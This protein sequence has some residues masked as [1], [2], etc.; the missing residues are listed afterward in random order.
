VP[1]LSPFGQHYPFII[2]ARKPPNTT[3]GKKLT[4]GDYVYRGVITRDPVHRLTSLVAQIK[5]IEVLSQIS[6]SFGKI[7]RRGM[8]KNAAEGWPKYR[9]E[10]A[11]LKTFFDPHSDACSPSEAYRREPYM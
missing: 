3:L 11:R 4:V 10:K 8:T 2:A 7:V 6:Y 1:G 5:A 9:N